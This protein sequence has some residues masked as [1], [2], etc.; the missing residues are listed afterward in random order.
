[1]EVVFTPDSTS[2]C[3]ILSFG[4]LKTDNPSLTKNVE[5]KITQRD[6]SIFA[7]MPYGS[8]A[9][10]GTKLIPYFTAKGNVTVD[11][12]AQISGVNAQDF[13]NEVIYTV[14]SENGYNQKEYKITLQE[15]GDVIYV[16][17]NAVGRNNGT[18]WKDAY[19][20]LNL[21]LDQAA[22]L[23]AEASAE[24]WVTAPQDKVYYSTNSYGF[25][26]NKEGS[27]TILGGF[28]GT[29]ENST[30]REFDD[31]GNLV[32]RTKIEPSS[33]SNGLFLCNDL[34]K[35]YVHIEGIESNKTIKSFFMT[36]IYGTGYVKSFNKSNIT[37][38]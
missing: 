7:L 17:I 15:S 35:D 10:E 31:K 37:K 20:D 34:I 6:L 23:P 26:L 29:E 24:I 1:M 14:T 3:E 19:I 21:A 4:F 28:N 16:D 9:K 11:G 36:W 38:E 32:N 8:G 2:A 33:S 5:A 12:I 13:S 30:D 22:L 25:K 27:I 18:S